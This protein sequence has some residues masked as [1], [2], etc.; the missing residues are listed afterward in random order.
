MAV[1]TE[2][3][4]EIMLVREEHH[5]ETFDDLARRKRAAVYRATEAAKDLCPSGPII[6]AAKLLGISRSALRRL[7]IEYGMVSVSR[8]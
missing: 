5:I 3:E 2:A 4:R 6:Y 7:R 1:E 8:E